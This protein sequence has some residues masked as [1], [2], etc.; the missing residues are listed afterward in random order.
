MREV[1][2]VLFPFLVALYL[3][4]CVKYISQYHLL[5]VSNFGINFSL[6]RA[7]FH[8]AGLSPLSSLVIA[9]NYPAFFTATGLYFLETGDRYEIELYNA[10]EFTFLPYKD[11]TKIE[12]DGGTV[13][14]NGKA[15][16]KTPSHSVARNFV[17]FVNELK[18]LDP[19]RRFKRIKS[20]LSEAFDL[21]GAV[22][23]KLSH[24]KLFLYLKIL[25]GFLFLNTF[26]LLPLVLYSNLHAH[27]NIYV[28]AVYIASS[29]LI[30]VVLAHVGHKRIYGGEKGQRIYTLFSLVCLPVS[31]MHVM[32]YLTRDMYSRF[33]YLTTAC[34]LMPPDTFGELARKG[35]YK[36]EYLASQIKNSDWIES[37]DVERT[38]VRTL[39]KKAGLSIE[40]LLSVPEK[41]DELAT[42]YCP[43]CL[44]EYTK[45]VNECYDCG[46]GLKKF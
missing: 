31:A 11:I 2:S 21:Q 41:Q 24:A 29:Y 4:D 30:I 5:F 6:K 32:G 46:V 14:I 12:A 34:A 39:L 26:V 40:A 3:L 22:S 8:F 9:H 1:F 15:I 43:Y 37:L 44:C 17:N 16:V 33:H 38:N 19:S 20:L 10:E 42:G 45:D 25:C 35:L 28:V 36:I 7:G 27:I 13:R 18:G 23:L